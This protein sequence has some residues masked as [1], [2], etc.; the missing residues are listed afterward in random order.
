VPPETYRRERSYLNVV[1][2]LSVLTLKWREGSANTRENLRGD[3][4]IFLIPRDNLPVTRQIVRSSREN[5]H[6]T[7]LII[8]SSRENLHGDRSI[9]SIPRENLP[10]TW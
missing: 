8:E 10:G 5:L 2:L 9:L 7:R 6:G 3:H 1:Y 4:D